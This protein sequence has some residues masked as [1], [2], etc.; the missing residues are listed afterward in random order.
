MKAI[1]A[2]R[3]ANTL[4]SFLN[5]YNISVTMLTKRMDLA[6]RDGRPFDMSDVRYLADRARTD[7]TQLRRDINSGGE[8][9]DDAG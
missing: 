2:V 3:A 1:T 5:Q 9:Q 6:A 4:L 7:L 8:G